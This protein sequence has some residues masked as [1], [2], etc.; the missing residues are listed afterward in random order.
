MV[1]IGIITAFILTAA[2]DGVRRA[3][4][5]ATQ[6]LIMK[7]EAGM[8][9]RVDAILATRTDATPAHFYL[10]GVFSSSI[11]S[12]IPLSLPSDQR[13]QIVARFDQIKAELPDVFVVQSDTNYPI[14]FAAAP[15]PKACAT[16]ASSYGSLNL[17]YCQ[18]LLP[19][20]SG[21]LNDPA[22]LYNTVNSFGSI[23]ASPIASAAAAKAYNPAT[24]NPES[25]GIFGASY[26]AAAGIYKNLVA[27][28]INGGATAPSTPNAGYDGQDNDNNGLIDDLGENGA[29][30]ANY[31]LTT[32][33]PN[34][35]H[36]T[37]RAEM[38]YALLVEGQGPL[39]SVFNRDDFSDSEVKDTD[40]DGLPEFVDAWG[41]PLQFYRWP[42]FYVSDTQKGP[43]VYGT[44]FD[45]RQQNPLDPNQKL[46]DPLWWSGV[47]TKVFAANDSAPYAA[48]QG[49][50]S[51][52]AYAF[53]VHYTMLTDPNANPSVT[54]NLPAGV[55]LWDRGSIWSARRAY[56]SRFLILSGGPDKTPGVPV[57][58]TSYYLALNSNY[59]VTA[60]NGSPAFSGRA[61]I[62]VASNLD[63]TKDPNINAILN[64]RIECQAARATFLRTDSVYTTFSD[65]T[66]PE[67]YG[68][69]L[70]TDFLS[71]AIADA[72]GDDIVN[73]T[74]QGPGGATQ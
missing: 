23:P 13:A 54:K 18:Y 9:D 19:F 33:L 14:N 69:F 55:P 7:L 47:P 42:V 36:K 68:F 30:V 22:A 67:V 27:A 1:V 8:A 15:F 10:S 35:T 52:A 58:D 29:S 59:S 74:L 46:L 32:L 12:S 5:R 45:T 66:N 61:P 56:N 57:F 11:A 40:G 64:L 43:G 62:A 26:T 3:E 44:A 6:A 41:E 60:P 28:A 51:S 37:A 53:Q 31:I 70:S 65:G 25:T 16:A 50:L 72:G 71:P 63:P 34:H 17:T 48:A 24:V 21:V 39:G 20:G 2:A 49:P 73:Q 4:E 38:L